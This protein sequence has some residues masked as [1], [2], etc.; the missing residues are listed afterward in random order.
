MPAPMVVRV[1]K[2]CI[3]SSRA[4]DMERLSSPEHIHC[5]GVRDISVGSLG[6]NDT[7]TSPKDRGSI[8]DIAHR[9]PLFL[10]ARGAP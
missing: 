9:V 4:W 10:K 2:K 1:T 6:E 5:E 3:L 8:I 7:T